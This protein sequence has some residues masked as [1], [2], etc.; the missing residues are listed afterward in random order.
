MKRRKFIRYSLAGSAILTAFPYHLLAG[1]RKIYPY[2]RIRLG[3]TGIEMSRMA[4]GTGT[5]G[6]NRSSNQTRQ[7]GIKG[8]SDLLRAGF[9]EG[10]NFWDSADAYGSHPHLK[11]ALKKIDRDQV[12]ILTKTTAKTYEAAKNDLERFRKEIGT[13]YLD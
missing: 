5:S 1:S 12:V 9:D 13:D 10:I 4:M 6:S 8:L 2:D 3:N 7:L 11:E